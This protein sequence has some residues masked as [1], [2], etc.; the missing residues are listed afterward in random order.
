MR[1]MLCRDKDSYVH[2]DEPTG[3]REVF[4]ESIFDSMMDIEFEGHRF[5]LFSDWDGYLTRVYGDYMTPPPEGE[6]VGKH[7]EYYDRHMDYREWLAGYYSEHP[8][9]DPSKR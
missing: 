8:E 2:M 9:A 4:P 1:E 6:R 5:R 3:A 7:I